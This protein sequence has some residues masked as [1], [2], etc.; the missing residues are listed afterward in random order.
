[1]RVSVAAIAL[2]LGVVVLAMSGCGGGSSNSPSMMQPPPTPPPLTLD[3]QYR[4]SASSPFALNCEGAAGSGTV[5]TNAEVEPSLAI[6]PANLHNL[7]GVWQQDRW[8][9]GG[10]RGIVAGASL[11]G[12]TTWSHH[13]LPFTRCAGGSAS[14]GGDYERASDPWVTIAADGTAYQIALAFNGLVLQQN[15]VSA[16]VVSRS[17]DGGMTWG[18]TTTLIRDVTNF[19]NDKCSITAD[20]ANP[21]FVYAVWDRPRSITE[22]PTYFARSRDSGASWEMPRPIYDPGTNMQTINNI[23]VVLPNGTLV[24]FFVQILNDANGNA[25]SSFL[26]VMRSTD[27]GV[28]W[29]GPVKIADNLSVGTR[30]PNTNTPVRDSTITPSIAVG[31]GGS[32]FAAWQDARFSSGVRDGIAL[33]RS[34]DGGVTW[35]LPTR[36]NADASVAAFSPSAHVR[37]DGTIGVSYYDFRPSTNDKATL[38]TDYWLARSGDATVWH[39]SQIAGPFDLAL[40]P[41]STEANASAYFLGDYQALGSVG[42]VFVPFFVQTNM[43][44][45]NNRTDVFAAPAVSVGS[46]T[47]VTAAEQKEISTAPTNALQVFRASPQWQR[48]V[49]EN[50]A[51]SLQWRRPGGREVQQP[52]QGTL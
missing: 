43:G 42:N 52:E 28:T 14:N 25:V 10:A 27:N 33:A 20:S 40:A 49:R 26:G 19:F 1:M 41:L 9:T 5:Y 21:H 23:I 13:A 51:R 38:Y 50:L 36:V 3:P 29:S 4:A 2:I 30:D 7:I 32:L 8:S 6:N 45:L 35:S 46:A 16:V 44:D 37:G 48:R 22:A 39:E 31:P 17:T 47:S 12:G 34:D 18:P 15:S 24:D 11:D